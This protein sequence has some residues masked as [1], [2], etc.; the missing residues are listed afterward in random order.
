MTNFKNLNLSDDSL[1][2]LLNFILSMIQ[3][4]RKNALDH[5]DTLSGMLGGPAGAEGMTSLELQLLLNDLSTALTGFIKNSAQST[6]QAIKIAQLMANHLT[7]MDKSS[8]L[9][10]QDRDQ[11]QAAVSGLVEEKEELDNIINFGSD[12]T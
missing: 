9:S 7:K 6:E 3:E 5:H 4:D 12:S 10:E 11:I 1:V 8:T 2:G